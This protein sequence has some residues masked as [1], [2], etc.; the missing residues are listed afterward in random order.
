MVGTVARKLRFYLDTSVFGSLF[1]F[2]DPRRIETAKKLMEGIR[3]G[4]FEGFIS[5][6]VLDEVRKS[7]EDIQ[8]D[9][10]NII[11]ELKL[12]LLIETEESLGLAE[13]YLEQHII[14]E[15]FRDDARHIAISV[16]Y[17]V[18]ALISWN[19]K[20]MVNIRVK[21]MVNAVNLRLGY[22]PI[23]ILSPEEVVEYGEMES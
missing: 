3:H 21:K 15:K 5:P 10:I 13:N 9:L 7:P 12:P 20:H 19:Y 16:F 8:D 4:G 17:E 23:D 11:G 6:L 2:E 22:K 18:D 1:D 14:P